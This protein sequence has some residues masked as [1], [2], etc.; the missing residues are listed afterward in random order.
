MTEPT[1]FTESNALLAIQ[2][3]DEGHARE[4]LEDMLPNE[5]DRLAD[6]SERLASLA[7]RERK[8]K[9]VL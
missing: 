3:G 1:N 4:I 8:R 5:L 2:D 6:A 7:Q 9:L